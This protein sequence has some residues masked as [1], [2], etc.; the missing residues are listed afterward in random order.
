MELLPHVKIRQERFGVIVFDKEREKF[1][2]ADEVGQDVLAAMQSAQ[3]V[4]EAVEQL[5]QKYEASR[6]EI[7]RDVSWFIGELRQAGLMQ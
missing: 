4:D 1:F 6:E 3:T 7:R 2:V 5:S